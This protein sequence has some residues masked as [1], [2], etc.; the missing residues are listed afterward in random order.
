MPARLRSFIRAEWTE[1]DDPDEVG[2]S[3]PAYR[4]WGQERLEWGR[5]HG[6]PSVD[7]IRE[8]VEMRRRACG[9]VNDQPPP[10]NSRNGHRPDGY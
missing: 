2:G 7:I 6:V 8:Q 10:V 4:R 9:W 1:P 3:D 5:R